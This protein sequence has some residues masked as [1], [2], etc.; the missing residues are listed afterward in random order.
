MSR[1][2]PVKWEVNLNL[3][4]HREAS[5]YSIKHYDTA[6]TTNTENENM[7]NTKRFFVKNEMSTT[8]LEYI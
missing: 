7:Y 3:G 5:T 8:E 4:H 6:Q 1:Q 2:Q